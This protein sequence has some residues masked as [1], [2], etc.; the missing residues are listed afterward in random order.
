MLPDAKGVRNPIP[1]VVPVHNPEVSQ[2]IKDFIEDLDLDEIMPVIIDDEENVPPNDEV[3]IDVPEA[4]PEMPAQVEPAVL[5]PPLIPENP[6]VIQLLSTI[7]TEISGL[8]PYVDSKVHD[9]DV[10]TDAKIAASDAKI[11][12]SEAKTATEIEGLRNAMTQL[13]VDLA[14]SNARTRTEI[15]DEVVV[16]IDQCMATLRS[17]ISAAEVKAG[18]VINADK[19]DALERLEELKQ[20]IESYRGSSNTRQDLGIIVTTFMAVIASTGIPAY[21]QDAIMKALMGAAPG[22]ASCSAS[23]AIMP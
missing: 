17:E 6:Q 13:R 7:A 1:E 23:A 22:M 2:E 12:A 10:K 20:S 18:E 21:W 11:A 14:A 15:L 9:L 3:D 4:V 8:R 19:A 5:V 16:M